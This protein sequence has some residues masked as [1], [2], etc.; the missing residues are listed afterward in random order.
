MKNAQPKR[1]GVSCFVTGRSIR[2]CLICTGSGTYAFASSQASFFAA[3]ILVMFSSG[4]LL[5]AP[6]LV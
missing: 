5:S 1:L 2:S 4:Y 3:L 6:P